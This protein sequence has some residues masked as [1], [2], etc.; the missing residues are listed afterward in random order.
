MKK[1]EKQAIFDWGDVDELPLG[2]NDD[3]M[4]MPLGDDD[5]Q[6]A[7]V[8]TD[9]PPAPAVQE[10]TPAKAEKVTDKRDDEPLFCP[11]DIEDINDV[12]P[13]SRPEP[14]P[15]PPNPVPIALNMPEQ[16]PSLPWMARTQ[17]QINA[18]RK[19]RGEYEGRVRTEIDD[20]VK[21][22]EGGR[23]EVKFPIYAGWQKNRLFTDNR[24]A[25]AALN[26]YFQLRFA[27]LPFDSNGGFANA[28]YAADQVKQS[29]FLWK[30]YGPYIPPFCWRTYADQVRNDPGSISPAEL[31]RTIRNIYAKKM[32]DV[33]CAR[34]R[35]WEQ[36]AAA[37]ERQ[38][39]VS[40]GRT[41]SCMTDDEIRA[42]RACEDV[43]REA[44]WRTAYMWQYSLGFNTSR[45]IGG[46]T[47]EEVW[48]EYEAI[49]EEIRRRM[50]K[51]L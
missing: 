17:A 49:T 6:R 1:E 31:F 22:L 28:A 45:Y 18:I 29:I 3:I 35:E 30:H 12:F 21:T 2:D 24:R 51:Y 43:Q 5:E 27:T 32:F 16:D 38:R 9:E 13:N 42:L 10:T 34:E 40:Y 25:G 37:T 19:T 46:K 44:L 50:E 7:P 36:A 33:I 14:E 23:G 8:S 15:Q 4:L 41:L 48:T 47:Y 26:L 39:Q 11:E 20:I